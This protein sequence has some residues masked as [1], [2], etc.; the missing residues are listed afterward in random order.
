VLLT[1]LFALTEIKS[2]VQRAVASVGVS[3]EW[4]GL[5]VVGPTGKSLSITTFD[6]GWLAA[7][8]TMLLLT[9][10]LTALVMRVG[11]RRAAR[12]YREAF[13]QIRWAVLTISSVLALSYVMNLSGMAISLGTWL[14]GIGGAFALLSGFLGWFGVALTGSDTSSNALFGA[15]QVAAAH[16]IGV[17]PLL[18]AA[19]NSTGGV[20]GKAAAMQNLCLAASAVGMPGREGDILRKVLGWSLA[21]LAL[22]C[23]FAYLQTSVLSWMVP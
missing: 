12:C 20:Q 13:G 7:A 4:P 2:P 6:F 17:S 5:S 19:T 21:L 11:P 3:F 8:G 18:L 15:M 1:V 23:L 10:V 9:G 22:F 14:A 16:R